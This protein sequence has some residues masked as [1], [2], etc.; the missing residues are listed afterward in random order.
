MLECA[1]HHSQIVIEKENENWDQPQKQS[2]N[3]GKWLL[4]P[5]AI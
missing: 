5:G 2:L 1:W 4:I 3:L